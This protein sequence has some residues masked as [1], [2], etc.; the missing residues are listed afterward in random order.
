MRAIERQVVKFFENKKVALLGYG[1]E[2]RSSL[3]LI[4]S[5][6]PKSKVDVWDEGAPKYV[7]KDRYTK[8]NSKIKFKKVDFTSYDIVLIF[9]L[10]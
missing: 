4:R 8:I 9:I 1:Q 10:V 2:S 3:K 6:F 7:I 5:Y